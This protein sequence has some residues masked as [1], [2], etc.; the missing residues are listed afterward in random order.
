MANNDDHTNTEKNNSSN[1][2]A[3]NPAAAEGLLRAMPDSLQGIGQALTL[4]DLKPSA[5][6]GLAVYR[7][8]Y[9]DGAAWAHMRDALSGAAADALELHGRADA[10]LPRLS[11]AF[12]EDRAALC[13]AGVADV[14]RRFT[15]WA[16]VELRRNWRRGGEAPPPTEEEARRAG[17]GGPGYFAGARYNYCLLVDEVCLESLD[18]MAS[19]VVKLVRKHFADEGGRGG[20]RPGAVAHSGWEG[21]VTDSGEEDVGWMYLPVADYVDCCNQ[22]HDPEFWHDGYYVRPPFTF[23]N[24][25]FASAPGFWRRKGHEV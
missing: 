13:G 10:L 15:A 1:S 19:P 18:R 20:G 4:D 8:T 16:A 7:T 9:A 5:P 2:R 6:W 3:A 17:V 23:L 11:H 24:R 21:G 25:D 22:L 12:I 14:R